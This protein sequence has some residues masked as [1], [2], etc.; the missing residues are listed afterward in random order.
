MN[1]RGAISEATPAELQ[2]KPLAISFYTNRQDLVLNDP[3]IAV[4]YLNEGAI[5]EILGLIGVSVVDPRYPEFFNAI[6]AASGV[7]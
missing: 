6:A 2:G 1:F 7:A 4:K 5:R 3:A